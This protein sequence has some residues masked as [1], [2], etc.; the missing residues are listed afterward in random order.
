MAFKLWQRPSSP[1]VAAALL[2]S[3]VVTIIGSLALFYLAYKF[4]Y[5]VDPRFSP[6]V[7]T[8]RLSNPIFVLSAFI[9]VP[10]GLIVLASTMRATTS[11]IVTILIICVAV[12]EGFAFL[13][14]KRVVASLPGIVRKSDGDPLQKTDCGKIGAC[15]YANA[16]THDVGM[17]DGKIVFDAVY[18]VD[19]LGVRR[20]IAKDDKRPRSTFV[21]VFGDSNT[22]GMNVSDQQTLAGQIGEIACATQPYN[23]AVPGGSTASMLAELEENRVLQV[24]KQTKGFFIYVYNDGHPFRNVGDE[25]TLL[26]GK[27]F[28]AYDF[29][30]NGS[31]FYAGTLWTHRV[32]RNAL[33]VLAQNTNT[34]QALHIHFLD[35]ETEYHVQL[36]A[37]IIDRTAELSREQ[38]PN[39][40]F[41]MLFAPHSKT[42]PGVAKRL[43]DKNI[44]VLDYSGLIADT[45]TDTQM[46][47]GH[48]TSIFH[49]AMAEQVV[50]DLGLEVRCP[51]T[52]ST[53]ADLPP[54]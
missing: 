14:N 51:V 30:K 28:P 33:V 31:L 17:I 8:G 54:R 27:N 19:E 39:S 42:G 12:S 52:E 15:L 20:S 35:T 46:A 36:T 2:V 22:F 45:R 3:R 50:K 1:D 49:K 44:K 10:A 21:S 4:L 16:H 37:A 11:W 40:K 41:V 26:F 13:Y 32:F 25:G 38:F 48:P 43:R 47:E 5:S 9:L 29:D 23:L 7:V 6:G 18:N 34:V 53:K 24:V